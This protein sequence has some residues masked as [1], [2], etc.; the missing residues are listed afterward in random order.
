MRKVLL[1]VVVVAALLSLATDSYAVLITGHSSIGTGTGTDGTINF[2]VLAPTDPEYLLL[3]PLL[4]ATFSPGVVFP[5]PALSPPLVFGEFLY[6]YQASNDNAGFDLSTQTNN[7]GGPGDSHFFSP[8]SWGH[9]VGLVMTDGGLPITAGVFGAD[10]STLSGACGP[11]GAGGFMDAGAAFG[12]VPGLVIP[13][14]TPGATFLTPNSISTSFLA[15]VIPNGALGTM[16]GF[17]SPIPP[18]VFTGALI[19]G[20]VAVFGPTPAPVP[21]PNAIALLGA[22]LAA[23]SLWRR[24]RS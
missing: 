3:F 1:P 16:M 24:R 8:S 5:G 21:E 14:T 17:T 11:V 4:S 12:L 18:A 9:F 23:L 19:D 2:A 20:G 10:C 7:L 13:P 22:G 6:L 15:P